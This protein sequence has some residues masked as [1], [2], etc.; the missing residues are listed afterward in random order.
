MAVVA[1]VAVVVYRWAKGSILIRSVALA[2][3]ISV[4]ICL[5]IIWAYTT[6]FDAPI[7]IASVDIDIVGCNGRTNSGP[8][9]AL[10]NINFDRRR[11]MVTAHPRFEAV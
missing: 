10:C 5:A 11:G 6:W 4:G 7:R 2:V 9:V 8:E 3:P 1:A